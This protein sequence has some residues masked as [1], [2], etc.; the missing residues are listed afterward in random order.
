MNMW[1]CYA[2]MGLT[3]L[4]TVGETIVALYMY[5]VNFAGWSTPIQIVTPICHVLFMCAQAYSS[6]IMWILAGKHRRQLGLSDEPERGVEESASDKQPGDVTRSCTF[7][8][9]AGQSI[10]YVGPVSEHR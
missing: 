3:I 6:K 1:F 7:G 10:P 8:G 9:P 4:G 5:G 2:A